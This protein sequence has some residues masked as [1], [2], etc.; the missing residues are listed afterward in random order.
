MAAVNKTLEPLRDLPLAT[1]AHLSISSDGSKE[2]LC[3]VCKLLDFEEIFFGDKAYTF[4][5][6]AASTFDPG[7]QP[8]RQV[9]SN[10]RDTTCAFCSLILQTLNISHDVG[11]LESGIVIARRDALYSKEKEASL[12]NLYFL[13]LAILE[14]DSWSA[15]KETGHAIAV[16]GNHRLKVPNSMVATLRHF[17][18]HFPPGMVP[19]STTDE[20]A[21]LFDKWREETGNE[22]EVYIREI[23]SRQVSMNLIA[24]WMQRCEKEHTAW[25]KTKHPSNERITGFRVINV[26]DGMIVDA[27]PHCRYLA[28]SYVWGKVHQDKYYLSLRK[29][30][31]SELGHPGALF[32][33]MKSLPDTIKD[34]I[35]L[36]QKLDEKYLW[37]DALC[38]IQDSSEDKQ[39]QIGK[40]DIIYRSALLTIVAAAGLDANAGLP[41][42]EPSLPRKQLPSAKV[43]SLDLLAIPTDGEADVNASAW[44]SRAWT[45]QER[46]LSTRLLRL[47][48]TCVTFECQEACWR[49]DLELQ[50]KE[51][52]QFRLVEQDRHEQEIRQNF[53]QIISDSE[54][55]DFERMLPRGQYVQVFGS[56]FRGCYA[57]LVRDYTKRQLTEKGDMLNAFTGIEAALS[58]SLGAFYWG[59]PRHLLAQSLSWISK[60][61]NL[62]IRE[63]FPSWS[64]S[65]WVFGDGNNASYPTTLHGP[66]PGFVICSDKG[67]MVYWNSECLEDPYIGIYDWHDPLL[68][69]EDLQTAKDWDVILQDTVEEV[70]NREDGILLSSLVFFWTSTVPIQ[71][72][73]EEDSTSI[74]KGATVMQNCDG[75]VIIGGK[76]DDE[77]FRDI[78]KDLESREIELVYFGVDSDRRGEFCLILVEWFDGIARRICPHLL[79]SISG[80]DW[81]AALPMLR[82]VVLA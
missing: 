62:S 72:S 2:N 55:L 59:M 31:L 52:D 60:T 79:F 78:T 69:P 5:V 43:A 44:N 3:A 51:C 6:T 4:P 27:P 25:C 33:R 40:M 1:M 80:E 35:S 58:K 71:V 13:S 36:C 23:D 18:P 54:T 75:G 11:N 63:G 9:L 39:A 34:S 57:P 20:Q 38:I 81:E 66:H 28:L 24:G 32:D 26:K 22:Y 17:Y 15:A 37:V 16:E 56:L 82:M 45:F 65:G 50:G 47:T 68:I 53:H 29:E 10:L 48:P 61:R 42:V 77:D 64:W 49:E 70:W 7:H 74:L 21:K 12:P 67:E 19:L 30:N 41:G 14:G 73:D 8:F 46:L 76:P